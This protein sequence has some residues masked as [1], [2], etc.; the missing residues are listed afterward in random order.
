MIESEEFKIGDSLFI[1]TK[2]YRSEKRCSI[3]TDIYVVGTLVYSSLGD[4]VHKNLRVSDNEPRD[5]KNRIVDLLIGVRGGILEGL[6]HEGMDGTVEINGFKILAIE[7]KRLKMDN[8]AF[9]IR[10]MEED[11]IFYTLLVIDLTTSNANGIHIKTSVL[12]LSLIYDKL[13]LM[14][15]FP[16]Y[17][18][19]EEIL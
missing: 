5:I 14:K 15:I 4:I 10:N 1:S 11:S 18:I 19:K 17:K 7:T 9:A 2:L 12:C 16:L 3:S 6:E 13:G 8:T